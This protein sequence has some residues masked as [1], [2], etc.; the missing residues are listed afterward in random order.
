[1]YTLCSVAMALRMSVVEEAS[2][3]KLHNLQKELKKEEPAF[4]RCD[5]F[6]DPGFKFITKLSLAE[7]TGP[8][9]ELEHIGYCRRGRC[10]QTENLSGPKIACSLLVQGLL[11]RSHHFLHRTKLCELQTPCIITEVRVNNLILETWHWNQQVCI[12][13]TGLF[14]RLC[15]SY[16]LPLVSFFFIQC[17]LS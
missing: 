13:L 4:N 1:M 7:I 3:G 14:L 15:L 2:I 12:P 6:K 16:P 5:G 10:P 9:H 17:I 8:E 11:T